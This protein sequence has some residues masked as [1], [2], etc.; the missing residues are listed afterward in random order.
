MPESTAKVLVTGGLGFIGYDS[1]VTYEEAEPFTTGIKTP[2]SSK[3]KRD[4][5]FKSAMP[6][7]RGIDMT[8]EWFK[9]LYQIDG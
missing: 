7:E 9:G 3:A 2:D 4:L 8:I 6:V 1:L 5:E